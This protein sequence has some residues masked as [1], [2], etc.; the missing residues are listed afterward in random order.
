MIR[1]RLVL[2]VFAL[3]S[4]SYAYSA[5]AGP[6]DYYELLS[7]SRNATPEELKKAYRK[8]ALKYHPDR[9]ASVAL[10]KGMKDLEKEE[11]AKAYEETFKPIATAYDVLSDP[12]K[13]EQYDRYG[14]AASTTSQA[15]NPR[16]STTPSSLDLRYVDWDKLSNYV[17]NV[18]SFDQAFH[19]LA[20]STENL[21]LQEREL[22]LQ[23]LA[24][25]AN[26]AP[27]FKGKSPE[28]ILRAYVQNIYFG[29]ALRSITEYEVTAINTISM[30]LNGNMS[31]EA[32]WTFR[33]LRAK[34]KVLT[35]VPLEDRNPSRINTLKYLD[36]QISMIEK[37]SPH[38]SDS[39]GE[40]RFKIFT[41]RQVLR[42][43]F[44][45]AV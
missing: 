11:L 44:A 35:W 20:Q 40:L 42:R 12:K 6:T 30:I 34:I 37:A 9:A 28:Q 19:V 36:H 29:R 14:D 45:I 4:V 32:Y 25:L 16:R 3:H 8:L 33:E 18:S 5:W 24:L 23:L 43:I 17:S 38:Y 2:L 22:V 10:E 13:R 27:L 31:F 7:V 41:C 39:L 1:L 26:K 21:T 15:N